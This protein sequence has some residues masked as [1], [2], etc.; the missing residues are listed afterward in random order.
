MFA[1]S[2][3]RA[4]ARPAMRQQSQT[5]ASEA[6]KAT[7]NPKGTRGGTLPNRGEP[8]GKD[9]YSYGTYVAAGLGIGGAGYYLMRNKKA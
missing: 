1:R 3:I 9:K 6:D 4:A 7:S 2:A 5:Y 8:E